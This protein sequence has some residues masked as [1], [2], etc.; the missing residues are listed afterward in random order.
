M[1]FPSPLLSVS[2]KLGLQAWWKST[3]NKLN[4]L[5]FFF[6]SFEH[7]VMI[8][9][10]NIPLSKEFIPEILL[11][12]IFKSKLLCSASMHVKEPN[13]PH[14]INSI[15]ERYTSPFLLEWRWKYSVFTQAAEVTNRKWIHISCILIFCLSSV[16]HPACKK[17][18]QTKPPHLFINYS[19][20]FS[21]DLCE[22]QCSSYIW[23]SQKLTGLLTGGKTL[24]W[25]QIWNSYIYRPL[26]VWWIFF[27]YF[28]ILLFLPLK[29]E[30]PCLS[31]CVRVLSA[32]H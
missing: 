5:T 22:L 9:T 11:F 30:E 17:L 2:Y 26:K 24:L 8:R 20:N 29:R 15:T 19:K 1:C 27:L 10:H 16:L 13:L 18:R 23:S 28:F 4:N 12:E 25:A 21:K 6:A 14:E 31:G 3:F 7:K 32:F